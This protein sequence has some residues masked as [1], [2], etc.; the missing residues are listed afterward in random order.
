M[1][2]C[3]DCEVLRQEMAETQPPENLK[4]QSARQIVQYK[5][6]VGA[7]ERYVC[8]TCGA[9]WVRDLRPVAKGCPWTQAAVRRGNIAP[10]S[11]VRPA[12]NRAGNGA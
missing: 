11:R 12:W 7:I 1:A 2:L 5:R 9:R 6:N 8:R 10:E 4:F 3:A